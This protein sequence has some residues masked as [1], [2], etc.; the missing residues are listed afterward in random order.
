MLTTAPWQ[1][2]G[3]GSLLLTSIRSVVSESLAQPALR[4]TWCHSAAV[5]SG[6]LKRGRISKGFQA[7]V[8]VVAKHPRAHNAPQTER[9]HLAVAELRASINLTFLAD[10]CP[11]PAEQVGWF[12]LIG[13]MGV[14]SQLGGDGGASR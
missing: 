13:G 11:A 4:S 10:S 5:S 2:K 1:A 7:Q 12:Y 6:S 3:P 8:G 9:R 14:F